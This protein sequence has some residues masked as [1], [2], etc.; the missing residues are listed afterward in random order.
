MRLPTPSERADN[1]PEGFFT[2]YEGCFY[3]CFLWFPLPRL[4]VEYLWSYKIALAQIS[5]RGLRHLIGILVRSFEADKI[6]SLGHLRNFLE[7][8][9][10]PG[11]LE[12]YYIS[13]SKNK[14]IIGGFPSKDEKYTDH[15]FFVA[16]DEDSVPEGCLDKIVA[17][18]GKIDRD[19]T[20][21]EL[22]PEDLLETHEE[23]ASR[24]CHWTKHFRLKRVE[25]A[26]R[27]LRGVS[28]SSSSSSSDHRLSGFVEMQKAKMTLREKKA[29]EREAAEQ[30][31]ALEAIFKPLPEV[32]GAPEGS[33][34]PEMSDLPEASN[35]PEATDDPEGSGLGLTMT[36]VPPE[37]SRDVP[38]GASG[39]QVP[40]VES[41]EVVVGLAAGGQA[42]TKGKRPRGEH[43]TDKRKK[44]KSDHSSSRPIYKDKVASANLVASCA[45]PLLTAPDNLAEAGRYAETSANFL[46]A[47]SSMNTLVRYYESTNRQHKAANERFE[48]A[49]A[50]SERK[51]TEA[52][53]A[54]EKTEALVAA[55]QGARQ[56]EAEEN[57]RI[58]QRAEAE[59]ER[60][61]R[62]LSEEK[63]LREIEVA[64]AKK[65][66]KRAVTEEFAKQIKT[67]EAK[68]EQF[69]QVADRYM[70]FSQ[71]KANAEL[72]VALEEGKSIEDEK[73]EVEAWKEEFGTLRRSILSLRLSSS[74]L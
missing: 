15:F 71:A 47:F 4:I 35:R 36:S 5:T 65:A 62:L 48:L 27:L 31:R 46:K 40:E 54:R 74:E 34:R 66:A 6:L 16:I 41:T 28:C 52:T 58:R 10:S 50:E 60:L 29:A 72:I 45:W 8:R 73:K 9:R 17:K 55:E 49:R 43:S 24:K 30:K 7:V 59:I 14:K 51:I 25:K 42:K 19:P 39:T 33:G 22:V 68:L 32:T 11:P 53:A 26:L 20:F 56:K 2:L 12:R 63:S 69:D 61:N 38:A 18:W 21:L 1:P 70:Y 44:S 37:A 67:I 64:R 23:L 3:F 13:P 57:A